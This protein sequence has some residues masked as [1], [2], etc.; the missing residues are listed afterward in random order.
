MY[1]CF[2]VRISCVYFHWIKCSLNINFWPTYGRD[3]LFLKTLKMNN[4]FG[5]KPPKTFFT[6]KNKRLFLLK[7]CGKKGLSQKCPIHVL[8]YKTYTIFVI[9]KYLTL[10][11]KLLTIFRLNSHQTCVLGQ[12]NVR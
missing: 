10:M 8:K 7:F 11:S 6:I 1:V 4:Y 12:N 3:K 2:F 5:N 9:C